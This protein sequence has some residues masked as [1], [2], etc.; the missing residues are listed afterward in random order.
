M[1]KLIAAGAAL[2]AFTGT[3]VADD[4]DGDGLDDLT[5][6]AV[7]TIDDTETPSDSGSTDEPAAAP[8]AAGA[9]GPKMGIE[10]SFNSVGSVGLLRDSPLIH[11]LYNLGGNYLDIFSGLSFTNTSPDMGES[12]TEIILNLGGGYRMYKDMDG[13]IH[14][15]LEPYLLFT[16]FNDNDDT[17][18]DSIRIEAGAMLGVDFAVYDQFSL[19]AALGAGL[20]FVTSDAGSEFSIF[21]YTTSVNATFWWGK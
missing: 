16:L 15:Y 17:V 18:D 4:L 21:T 14:P 3:A 9:D 19:G 12:N 10:A 13:R 8:A 20:A 7:L 2:L 6:E 5:G 1:N 11:L